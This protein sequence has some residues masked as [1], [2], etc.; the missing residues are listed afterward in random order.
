MLTITCKR[1]Y[2]ID[3]NHFVTLMAFHV[4]LITY[5]LIHVPKFYLYIQVPARSKDTCNLKGHRIL[6]NQRD[7]IV[8]QI[9]YRLLLAR[10]PIVITLS[11]WVCVLLYLVTIY[12]R[13]N[14]SSMLQLI[15]L[16]WWIADEITSAHFSIKLASQVVASSLALIDLLWVGITKSK[17][18]KH[19]PLI[20]LW[21]VPAK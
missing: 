17:S 10:T 1:F 21:Y 3:E 11:R 5:H 12:P 9:I 14:L 2:E 20:C 6:T 19:P 16:Q 18:L 15:G 8:M 13:V 4:V 7:L